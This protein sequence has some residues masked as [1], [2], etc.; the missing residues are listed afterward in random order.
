MKNSPRGRCLIIS[1]K[2]FEKTEKIRKGTEHDV[3]N[4]EETFKWLE[5]DVE[6]KED[7]KAEDIKQYMEEYSTMNHEKFEC[8]VCCILSHGGSKGISGTDGKFVSMEDIQK[9]FKECKTLAGKPKLFFIQA[10]RG[11]V[12]DNGVMPEA[13]YDLPSEDQPSAPVE[14]GQCR[15]RSGSILSVKPLTANDFTLAY[16]TPPGMYH[17]RKLMFKGQTS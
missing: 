17:A 1:N 2:R 16:A 15:S 14:K 7:C 6:V 12:E 8:F 5:F 11:E 3:E 4:L 13:D 9:G 10:C